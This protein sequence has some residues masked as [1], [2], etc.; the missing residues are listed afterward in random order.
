MGRG[1]AVYQVASVLFSRREEGIVTKPALH[2]FMY[3][4][5]LEAW[6]FLLAL[7]KA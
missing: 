7:A 1:N 3:F 5:F 4:P 6:H 2:S